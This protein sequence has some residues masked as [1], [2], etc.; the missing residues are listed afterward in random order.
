M[1]RN[2]ARWLATYTELAQVM[3]DIRRD[4]PF[5][6]ALGISTLNPR[7]PIPLDQLEI[8]ARLL[9]EPAE[10]AR[11]PSR[12]EMI[13][14]WLW[15]LAFALR[16]SLSLVLVQWRFRKGVEDQLQ[17]PATIVLNTWA[18]GPET[19]RGAA[20]FYYGTLPQQLAERGVSCVMVTVDNR[21]GV[22]P[23]FVQAAL[24]RRDVR[25]VPETLLMP[26]TAPLRIARTQWRT[27]RHLRRLARETH[28]PRRALVC[29][30][31]ARAALNPITMRNA[32]RYD[33]ARNAVARWNA[34]VFVTFYEGQP[35][36]KPAWE[37]AKAANPACVVVGYQHTILLPYSVALLSPSRHSWELA[38]PHVVLTIGEVTRRMMEPGHAT[39]GTKL[40]SFGTFRKRPDGSA[41][42]PPRPQRRTVL[43]LPEGNLPESKL[44]F[45]F[46]LKAAA[47]LADHRFIFRCHP[48]LPFEQVRPHLAEAPEAHPNIEISRRDIVEDYARASIVLYRGSSAVL[49]AIGRGLKPIYLR[50]DGVPEIDPLFEVTEWRDVV[51]SVDDFAAAACVYARL[52]EHDADSSWRGVAEYVRRFSVPVDGEAIDRLLNTVGLGR[53]GLVACA[54]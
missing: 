39:L 45:G 22:D 17:G 19:L 21:G 40:M 33:V 38:A 7:H 10:E 20:D 49:Y 43:V 37:G 18:F 14:R 31:A 16:D 47:V 50:V 24:S 4:T 29:A 46:A 11:P 35:W 44:L 13:W 52:S 51:A 6:A 1:S 12:T 26:V 41:D 2:S 36:E 48:M 34:K 30:T 54:A 27:A 9:R 42:A 28:D 15:V 5:R 23:A 3:A 8:M 25:Y 32:L 53:R